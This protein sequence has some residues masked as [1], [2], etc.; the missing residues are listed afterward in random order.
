VGLREA[1]SGSGAVF[2][3]GDAE[4]GVPF[5]FGSPSEE[6]AATTT[7]AA[8]FDFSDRTLV[9]LTGSDRVKFLHSFC[10]NDVKRLGAGQGCEAFVPNVKGRVVGHV[11]IDATDSS[12]WLDADPGSAERLVPHLERY[13]I[14]EDV[15]IADRSAD[16]GE[17]LLA[18]P[19]AA[20]RLARVGIEVAALANLEHLGC[21]LLDTPARVRRFDVGP[22]RGY[23]VIARR[24]R[25]AALWSRLCEAGVRPAG[26]AVW[27][28]LRIEAG[29]PVCGVDITDENLVQEV[30]RTQTA[31]SFT[32]GCYLGQEPIARLDAMG[33]VNREL[34]SLRLAGGTVPHPGSR[35][36]SDAMATQAVGT[37][38]S[39]AFS[40]AS[41]SPVAMALLRSNSAVCGTPVFV[42]N[43]EETVVATVFWFP[44]QSN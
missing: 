3:P 36:F 32:K 23:A 14:N 11:W 42:E 37:V 15:A 25:L 38:T 9:E 27:T 28:A 33:H 7:A 31:V 21:N 41:H 8:L 44:I 19:E 12:L 13:V 40:F 5:H 39:A 10:T 26:S 24:D 43:S 35:V 34:R 16:W 1:Q 22:Q 20:D 18:G 6:Y 29:L 17:L 4:S 30:G 2:P